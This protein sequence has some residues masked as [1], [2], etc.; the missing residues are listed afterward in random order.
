LVFFGSGEFAVPSLRKLTNLPHEIA[1]VVTQPDRP[2]GRGKRPQPTPLAERAIEEGLPIERCD[3]VN[4]S[5][6]VERINSLSADLGIVIAFGQKIGPELRAAFPGE[7]VNLHASLLPK[8]RGAA[9]IHAA[10]LGGETITGVTVFRLVDRMDAGPILVQRRTQ[11]DRYE[12]CGELHDRLAAIGCDAID[13][14][15]KLFEKEPLPPGEPQDDALASKAPKLKK[16]DGYVRFDEPAEKIARVCRAM[17]PWPGARCRYKTPDGEGLEVMLDQVT[18]VPS[19]VSVPPGT[20]TAELTV[21]TGD[22]SLEIHAV[23]PAGGRVMGWQDFVNGR[24][25]RPGHVFESLS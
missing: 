6:F 11:I 23:K 10:L 15:L 18:P 9:P 3:N 8:Y 25:V 12:R 17:W 13:A 14:T 22:G 1:L 24:R 20:I 4:D 5:A 19:P 2:A 21:A 7:C 16:E